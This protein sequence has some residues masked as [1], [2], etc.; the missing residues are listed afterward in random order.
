MKYRNRYF[1]KILFVITGFWFHS[2]VSNKHLN[3]GKTSVLFYAK[4]WAV[5]KSNVGA[6]GHQ[7]CGLSKILCK[8]YTNNQQWVTTKIYTYSTIGRT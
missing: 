1:R 4:D 5:L 2:C 3:K 8:Q 6:R 7:F